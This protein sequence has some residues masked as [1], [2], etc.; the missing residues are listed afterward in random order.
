MPAAYREVGAHLSESLPTRPGAH[1]SA[2]EPLKTI[3]RF[4]KAYIAVPTE[5][6]I[7]KNQ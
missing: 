3:K 7:P 1:L 2:K 6:S 5:C 4:P